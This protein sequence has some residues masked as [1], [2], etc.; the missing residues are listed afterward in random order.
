MLRASLPGANAA[1][2][3]YFLVA[4]GGALGSMARHWLSVAFHEFDIDLFPFEM[5]PAHF[6]WATLM[7][8]I[9]GSLVIGFVANLPVE[10]ISRDARLFLMTGVLGGFTTFSS[11]S[12]QLLDQFMEGDVAL[13]LLYVAFSVVISLFA[14]SLGYVSAGLL[15]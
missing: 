12:L 7:I 1:M 8:N 3:E 9:G 5:M 15:Y 13:G 6:P 11:F 14:V 2:V 4:V 10:Y